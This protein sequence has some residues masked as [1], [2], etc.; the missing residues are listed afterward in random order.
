MAPAAGHAQSAARAPATAVNSAKEIRLVH[1][2]AG[3]REEALRQLA[4]RFNEQSKDY[5]LSVQ[6]GSWS[7]GN[8]PHLLILQDED[9]DRFLAG[10][11]RYKAVSAV[12]REGG[13]PLQALKASA[14]MPRSLLDAK[15]QLLALPVGQSTPVLYINR[16]EFARAGLDPN[17]PVKTWF[18][19]QQAL[20][21]LFDAG[22]T[23][24]YTVSEPG[25]VMVENTSAWH[26]EPVSAREGKG[27]RPSFNGMLQVK[28]VAMMASWHRARYLRIFEGE[29]EAEQKFASGECAVIAAPSASWTDFRRKAKFEVGIASLPYHDDF[30]GAPQ[31]TLADGAALWVAAGKKPAEYK[32]VARFIAF[33]LQPENQVAWQHES[34]YLPL[35]RSGVFAAQSEAL[36]PDLENVKVAVAQLNN[37]PATLDSGASSVL[38]RARVLSIVDE[39][40]RAVWADRKPA[41][42][43]LDTA[44]TRVRALVPA[45]R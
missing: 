29:R 24:P 44:V 39:E 45:V 3:E 6:A 42:E 20:G 21:R 31:N 32:A 4:A 5:Q 10:K 28:H 11:P 23:C 7:D 36:G 18:D 30:S 37:K 33:W 17:T 1:G 41:K 15:G 14:M 34:G 16:A 40:L 2:F 9:L 13:A 26:N 43:A 25:R 38:G 8:V 19:L 35:D 22:S 12:M 27:E